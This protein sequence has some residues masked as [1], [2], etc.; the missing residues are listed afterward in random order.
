MSELIFEVSPQDTKL[1]FEL[2]QHAQLHLL[3]LSRS[4]LNSNPEAI[5]GNGAINVSFSFKSKAS[6]LQDQ[7]FKVELTFKMLGEEEAVTNSEPESTS[8]SPTVPNT[9]AK[10]ELIATVKAVYEATYSLNADFTPTP[11]QL[12]AFSSANAIYNGW[13][14]F[15]QYLQSSL[16]QMGLPPYTAP[17]MRLVPKRLMPKTGKSNAPE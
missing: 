4:R 5:T 1:S 10:A 3:R 12:K 7:L 13:P 2:M 6:A 16:Q 9:A 11:A 17:F 8:E 14:Y 15:R